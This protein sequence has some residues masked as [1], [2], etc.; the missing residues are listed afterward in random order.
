VGGQWIEFT[1]RSGPG[2]A[3][4]DFLVIFPDTVFILEA[5]LTRTEEAHSQLVGLYAPLVGWIYPGRDLILI[6]ATKNLA[7][8]DGA[9]IINRP[10]QILILPR[11]EMYVW[12]WT[13]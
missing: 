3:Q 8:D 4:P 11:S 12:H 1:D 13:G 9:P 7:F 5:K 2:F 10:E 6:E